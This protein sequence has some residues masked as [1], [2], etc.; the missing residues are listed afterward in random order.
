MNLLH[1][2]SAFRNFTQSFANKS[3][4][5]RKIKSEEESL[6][7]VNVY[8]DASAR[9]GF[10]C[11]WEKEWVSGSWN[12]KCRNM[13]GT[14]MEFL[15]AYAMLIAMEVWAHLW[16][17]RQVSFHCDNATVVKRF[18]KECKKED[19][20]IQNL[21]DKITALAKKYN[22]LLKLVLADKSCDLLLGT[23]G[24]SKGSLDKFM[25]YIPD[26]NATATV[27]P[28]HLEL[29]GHTYISKT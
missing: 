2:K 3:K 24:L 14:N 27:V 21:F 7:P 4:K 13:H 12:E 6:N 16:V 1:T 9:Y 18:S 19:K 22:I 29:I 8:T 23:D 26:A 28:Q 20:D 5:S 11:V 17:R 10:G 15:E 25:K